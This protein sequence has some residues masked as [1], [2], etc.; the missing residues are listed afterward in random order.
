[1]ESRRNLDVA[2]FSFFFVA[3]SRSGFHDCTSTRPLI[4]HLDSSRRTAVQAI[5][6]GQK[7][8]ALRMGKNTSLPESKHET[9]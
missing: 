4:Q 7:A 2:I 8:L 6:V 9:L 5:C 3:K 1:M